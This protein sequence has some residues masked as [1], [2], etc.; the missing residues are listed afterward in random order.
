VA[1]YLLC[2]LLG[3]IDRRELVERFRRGSITLAELQEADPRSATARTGGAPP[4]IA[5]AGEAPED[6]SSDAPSSSPRSPHAVAP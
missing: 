1:G 3:T 5:E 2:L 4:P 6:L